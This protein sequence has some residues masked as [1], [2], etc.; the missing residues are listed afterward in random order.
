M[1]MT[2]TSTDRNLEKLGAA[3]RGF[4]LRGGA[5]GRHRQQART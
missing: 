4:D 3:A 5:Q 2:P 1:L